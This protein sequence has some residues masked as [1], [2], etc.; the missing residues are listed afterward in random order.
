MQKDDLKR[1]R[2][3][4]PRT[5]T[6]EQALRSLM[7]LCAKTEK[8]SGDARRLMTRWGVEPAAQERILKT[9]TDQRF[10][11]D[12]RYAAAFVR[13]KIRLSGWGAYKIRAALSAKRIAREVIDGALSELDGEA[14]QGRLREAM[15]R[16]MRSMDADTPYRTKGR[17]VR[18]GL[19][20]G[21]DYE[22]VLS[23][24]DELMN[25]E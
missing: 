16:R 5:K 23:L 6:P 25:E 18:Y 10:I 20:L 2:P 22:T 7:N 14:M 15:V 19:S 11:D 4:G 13:E 24:T 1:E 3:A 12:G 9:L 21:Y 17:L 8:C